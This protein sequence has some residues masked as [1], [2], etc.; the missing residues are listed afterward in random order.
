[1]LLVKTINDE[2]YKN[3][4]C[5]QIKLIQ[6]F[7]NDNYENYKNYKVEDITSKVCI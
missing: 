7:Y 2:L 6:L 4:N 1:M 5:F 3:Y